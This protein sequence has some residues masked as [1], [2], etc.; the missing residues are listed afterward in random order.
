MRDSYIGGAEHSIM[1]LLFS[2]FLAHFLYEQHLVP[3]PEPFDHLLTQGMVLGATY[4]DKETGAF[5]HPEDVERSGAKLVEKATGK[6]VVEKYL[7]M[8]KSKY[9]GIDPVEVLKQYGSDVVRVAMLMQCPP[10]NSFLYNK[11]CMAA[12]QDVVA[13]IDRICAICKEGKNEGGKPLDTNKFNSQFNKVLHDMNQFDF[14]NVISGLNIMMNL[15]ADAAFSKHYVDHVKQVLLF[16]EPFAPQKSAA[17]WRE[18]QAARCIGAQEAFEQQRWPTAA[19]STNTTV[20]VQVNGKMK[21]TVALEAAEGLGDAELIALVEKKPEMRGLINFTAKDIRV[22]HK[23]QRVMVNYMRWRVCLSL[24][25]REVCPTN[26]SLHTEGG[27]RGVVGLVGH[28]ERQVDRLAQVVFLQALGVILT[29]QIAVH[30]VDVVLRQ[31]HHAALV[32]RHAELRAVLLQR[33]PRAPRE[34]VTAR[35]HPRQ[36]RSLLRR[37]RHH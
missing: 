33:A 8:S 17:C 34:V 37:H 25:D 31:Q 1:H 19:R 21:K 15:L 18:L 12:A 36:A 27:V 9:N 26:R 5:L 7:K 3:Q 14:H 6:E 4:L 32:I 16:W 29:R 30:P 11:H 2:R 24:C 20:I 23:G 22:I 28:H 35:V 13:K 10:S